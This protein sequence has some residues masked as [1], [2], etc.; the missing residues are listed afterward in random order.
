MGVMRK[1]YKILVGQPE[2]KNHLQD[3]GIDG[4]IL[5]RWKLLK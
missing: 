2:G 5:L 3:L 1:G 4:R